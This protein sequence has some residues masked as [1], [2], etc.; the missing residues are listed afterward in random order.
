MAQIIA[1]VR[2]GRL[3]STYDF[4]LYLVQGILKFII[5]KRDEFIDSSP[6]K[7]D[8]FGVMKSRISQNL[9][10]LYELT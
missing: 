6:D 8:R 2:T 1:T 10:G 5:G 9:A 3:V 4:G 7:I